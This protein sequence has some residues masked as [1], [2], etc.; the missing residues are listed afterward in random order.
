MSNSPEFPVYNNASETKVNAPTTGELE[1]LVNP[2]A[3]AEKKRNRLQ[4]VKFGVAGLTIAALTAG[5]FAFGKMTSGE[6]PA[7]TPEPSASAPVT[8]G[9]TAPEPTPTDNPTNIEVEPAPVDTEALIES[10]RIPGDLGPQET[11]EA[12]MDRINKWTLAGADEKTISKTVGEYYTYN[13]GGLD[14]FLDEKASFNADIFSGAIFP[15]DW[16]GDPHLIPLYESAVSANRD[17]L[18]VNIKRSLEGD[19]IASLQDTVY[20]AEAHIDKSNENLHVIMFEVDQT[21]VNSTDKDDV[22]KYGKITVDMSD[23]TARLVNYVFSDK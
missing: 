4:T 17:A 20:N 23:G 1:A 14:D 7:P 6:N 12:F 21:Y 10:L 18:A 8:P 9:E 2:N 11:A 13:N 15:N 5:G 22:S 3:E 19:P 16:E